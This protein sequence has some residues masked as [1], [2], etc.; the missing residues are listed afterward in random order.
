M[1]KKKRVIGLNTNDRFSHMGIV[2]CGGV[3][4]DSGHGISL[5]KFSSMACRHSSRN[6]HI[7]TWKYVCLIT[8]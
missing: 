2:M 3:G 5:V 4:E 7:F 8:A 6:M 1:K